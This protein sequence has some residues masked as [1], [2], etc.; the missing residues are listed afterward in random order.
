[1]KLDQ[2]L[3]EQAKW[4]KVEKLCESYVDSLRLGESVQNDKQ[5]IFEA[6]IEATFG[7]KIWKEINKYMR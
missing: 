6:A 7:N 4:K 2:Y 5:Y 3:T 1:M